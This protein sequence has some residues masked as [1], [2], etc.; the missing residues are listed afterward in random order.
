MAEHFPRALAGQAVSQMRAS[1]LQE[2][3]YEDRPNVL[4]PVGVPYFRQHLQR[5]AS[6]P[7]VRELLTLAHT[8]DQLLKGKVASAADTVVQRIKSIEQNL[9]GSHYSVAQRLE[10]LPGDTMSLT[11]IP[12]ATA[13]QK[14]IYQ[15]AKAKWYASFPEGKA[16]K[17]Q[18]GQG[19]G[20]GEGKDKGNQTGDTVRKGG[21][22]GKGEGPKKKD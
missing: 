12:E 22:G 5:R 7:M 6:G 21:K 19:K 20:R 16:S 4:H 3:G 15:E 9:M 18:K 2:V 10:V 17:E 13:A 1:L 11:A 8:L 14:E